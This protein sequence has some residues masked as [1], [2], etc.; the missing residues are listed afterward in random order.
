MHSSLENVGVVIMLD[1][2]YKTGVKKSRLDMPQDSSLPLSHAYVKPPVRPV[3]YNIRCENLW[4]P[5]PQ[6]IRALPR[7]RSVPPPSYEW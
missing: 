3:S 2:G 4:A 7:F 6:H 1:T 5:Y